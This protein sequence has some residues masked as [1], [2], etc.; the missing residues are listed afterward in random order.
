[1]RTSEIPKQEEPPTNIKIAILKQD[2]KETSLPPLPP[3][4]FSS[5]QKQQLSSAPTSLTPGEEMFYTPRNLSRINDQTNYGTSVIR[6]SVP[7]PRSVPPNP[8]TAI[9]TIK[10]STNIDI[11]AVTSSDAG[12]AAVDRI[13]SSH[14][15]NIAPAQN[16]TKATSS[17]NASTTAALTR[18][19]EKAKTVIGKLKEEN[20]ALN[21]QLQ[22]LTAS[23]QE[24][25]TSNEEQ[26]QRELQKQKSKMSDLITENK[27]LN[28]QNIS[29]CQNLVRTPLLI[30]LLLSL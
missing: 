21:E 18:K 29:L 19:L 13:T 9:E 10:I 8:S 17:P 23:I 1:M 14:P 7:I 16:D 5:P 25:Q 28:L 6:S 26:L 4:V 27:S 20:K 15:D 24:K 11:S 30:R 12:V 2:D 22:S 3:P